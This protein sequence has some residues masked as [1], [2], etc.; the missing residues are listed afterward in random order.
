MAE[1]CKDEKNCPPHGKPAGA[2]RDAFV[3]LN[4]C[5]EKHA[6][7]TAQMIDFGGKL[8]QVINTLIGTP[9][10]GSL[11]RKNGVV[12]QLKEIK[13]GQKGRWNAKEK[14]AIITAIIMAISAILTS[15]LK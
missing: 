15:L 7:V 2:H 13:E 6:N 4:D 5:L 8:D 9:E 10:P 12:Q 14:A 11:E 3:K 1:E